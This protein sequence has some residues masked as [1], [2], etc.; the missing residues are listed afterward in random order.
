VRLWDG[1]RWL[2]KTFAEIS[3]ALTL[4]S[5]KNYDVFVDDD[6]ATLVLSA[7]WTNDTTRADALGTQ[8]S[9]QVLNSDKTKLWLGTIRASAANVTEDSLVNRYVINAYNEVRRPLYTCP[10]YTDDD[11]ST[12][13]TH[14]ATTFT[15][16]NGGTGAQVNFLSLARH[17]VEVTL[18]ILVV[19]G[20]SGYSYFGIGLD[21]ATAIQVGVGTGTIVSTQA[22]SCRFAN[23][24]S[25]GK[26]SL[27][28]SGIIN[29]A[30][31][32]IYADVAR[33]AF[34]SDAD[35]PTTYLRGSVYG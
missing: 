8:D 10:A 30:N 13:Y 18:A 23:V 4:T 12:T 35:F 6:A 22:P 21:T 15:A 17:A 11:T 24:V 19:N 28:A 2:Y 27:L 32:T 34:G 7:A 26:H 33:T 14:S 9:V 25:L 1:T 29:T 31:A 20:A 3:L 16:L 5:G